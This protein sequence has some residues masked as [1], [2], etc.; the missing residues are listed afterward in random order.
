[1]DPVIVVGEICRIGYFGEDDS[2]SGGKRYEI[3]HEDRGHVDICQ[4]LLENISN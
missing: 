2:Y 1:M 3:F 4:H